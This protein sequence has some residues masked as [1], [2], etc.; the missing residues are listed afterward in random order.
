MTTQNTFVTIKENWSG[1][2][3]GYMQAMHGLCLDCHEKNEKE[4][5][6]KHR[7]GISTCSTCHAEKD[8]KQYVVSTPVGLEKEN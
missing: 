2:A 3:T 7:T 8:I 4:A 5:G 1:I 6:I